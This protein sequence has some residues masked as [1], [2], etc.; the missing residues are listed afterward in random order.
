M[1]FVPGTTESFI[2]L[3]DSSPM[4]GDKANGIAII[5]LPANSILAEHVAGLTDTEIILKRPVKTP[6]ETIAKALQAA[7]VAE[8]IVAIARL[9]ARTWVPEVHLFPS[10]L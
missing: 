2:V 1:L 8:M 3:V 5:E 9:A 7:D 10:A 6:A 4:L